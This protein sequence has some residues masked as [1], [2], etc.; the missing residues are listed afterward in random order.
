[1][2]ES[3]HLQ[4]EKGDELSALLVLA[5]LAYAVHYKGDWRRARD[6]FMENLTLTMELDSERSSARVLAGLA[7]TIVAE[8]GPQPRASL[9]GLQSMRLATQLLGLSAARLERGGGKFDPARPGRV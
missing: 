6:L 1:M 3:L 4:R 8:V 7:G 5:N 9:E 2:T